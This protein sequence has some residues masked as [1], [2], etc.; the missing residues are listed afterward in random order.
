MQ[1]VQ[2]IESFKLS[3]KSDLK[4]HKGGNLRRPASASIK[5]LFMN[6]NSKITAERQTKIRSS[7]K[8]YIAAGMTAAVFALCTVIGAAGAGEPETVDFETDI[9][10][11]ETVAA[12]TEIADEPAEDIEVSETL[13]AQVAAFPSEKNI[14][15]DED[16]VSTS[17]DEST[18]IASDEVDSDI[19]ETEA[20]TTSEETADT[21]SDDLDE[22]IFDDED[23]EAPTGS[24]VSTEGAKASVPAVSAKSSPKSHKA[25]KA[26]VKIVV[27]EMSSEAPIQPETE[28]VTTVS[29]DIAVTEEAFADAPAAVNAVSRFEVPDWLTL[30]EN[31]V[32]TEYVDTISGKSCA[33]TADPGA[34][35]STGKAVFQGY[36]AVDPNIIPYG[37]E[38]YIVADD[39]EVY[40]YAIAADTGY[41]VRQGHIVVDLFMDEYNDCIQWG[42]KNVTIYVLK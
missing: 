22:E 9:I 33:Y 31:G 6:D 17:A 15:T 34:L 14:S 12:Q 35:M 23:S 8:K 11:T 32:P 39:G 36:V 13:T 37:S 4:S 1:S 42:A 19:A 21:D 41:S 7:V 10:P 16:A 20:V 24:F 25:D 30:D 40:G 27:P 26:E 5:E 38:L 3:V 18:E 29:E 2:R 28:A